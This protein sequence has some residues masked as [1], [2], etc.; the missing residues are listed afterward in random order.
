MTDGTGW[1]WPHF[2]R[3][4]WSLNGPQIFIGFTR[5]LYPFLCGLLISRLLPARM[6]ASNPA[7][8]PLRIKGGFWWASLILAAVFAVPCIGGRQCPADGLYQAIAII[9]VFPAV[10]LIGAGS[11][12]TDGRSTRICRFLG[13]IS[14][15]LYIT[16]FPLVCMQV[17]WVSRNPEAPLWM[18][19]AVSA[20][21][22]I[23]AVAIAWAWLRLYDMPV[24]KWLTDKWLKRQ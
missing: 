2:S 20:G 7:G 8:S 13:E 12:T 22:F 24:R 16:H 9:A 18:H 3:G 17:A 21:V 5:L 10:V 11:R 6:N 14:Y 15:P 23:S 4:G 1:T 19:I